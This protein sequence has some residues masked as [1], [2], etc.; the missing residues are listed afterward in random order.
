MLK[1]ALKYSTQVD[2]LHY[3]QPLKTTEF[4]FFYPAVLQ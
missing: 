4:V 1:N 2:I 3:C